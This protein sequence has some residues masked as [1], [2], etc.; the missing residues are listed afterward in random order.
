MSRL[1]DLIDKLCP[2]GV[3]FKTLGE[4]IQTIT[5]TL[6]I[7]RNEYKKT[8]NVPIIS[9]E[10]E[11]ISGYCNLNDKNIYKDKYVLFG[12]H[13]EHIKFVDF[14]FVQGADGLK[15]FK[16]DE[17]KIITKYLYY[18]ICNFYKRHDNYERHFKYLI[19]LLIPVPPIEVQKEI[20]RI[21]D[22]FAD[23]QTG[24]ID[25][26]KEEL[27][28]R[29]KQYEYYRDKLLTFD[30]VEFKK[31]GEIAKIKHG[32]DYRHLGVGEIPVYGSGGIMT[33]VDTFAYDKPTV[34]LPRKGSIS[35]IF[36][37]DK[38]FWNVD[39]IYYT[40]ID[41]NI[42]LPKFFYYLICKEHIEKLNTS[43]AARPALTREVLNKI[44]IPIPPL[45]E[46]E[47]IVNILDRFDKLCNDLSEGLPA[48]IKFRQQQYEY[49]RDKL[50]TFNEI[51]SK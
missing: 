21:L 50:L 46:Q 34:L 22:K 14:A 44:K 6:K 17:S 47:R 15:I 49:Y 19:E 26:L 16:C 5:P 40:E 41:E 27:T 3:E 12:D 18:A 25:L 13:S 23:G 2:H 4:I 45:D 42:I 28:L 7:K 32:K 20:V 11:Y 29:K 30:D 36:F 48:E 33:Y 10:E 38:P 39:T 9:Q 51:S 43:N 1:N 8:G 24:L 35:N 37:V 31:L